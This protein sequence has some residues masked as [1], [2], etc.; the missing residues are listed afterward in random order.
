MPTG[1]GVTNPKLVKGGKNLKKE[2]DCTIPK[3]LNKMKR[4]YASRKGTELKV[5]SGK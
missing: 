5:N 2:K 3:T 4:K 1:I